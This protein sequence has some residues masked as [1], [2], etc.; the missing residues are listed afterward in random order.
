[1]KRYHVSKLL[2]E[3]IIKSQTQ[4]HLSYLSTASDFSAATCH[5]YSIYPVRTRRKNQVKCSP[6]GRKEIIG[7]FAK[8]EEGTLLDYKEYLITKLLG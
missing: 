7:L 3:Q 2:G 6:L 5:H 4:Y 8:S 1:M